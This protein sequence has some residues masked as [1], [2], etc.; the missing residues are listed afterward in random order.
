MQIASKGGKATDGLRISISA[1]SNVQFA[2]ANVNASSIW[3]KDWQCVTSSL[4]LL[5]HLLLRSCR[6]DAR[7]ADSEQTPNRDRRRKPANVIT[8]LYATQT[9][10]FRSGL[11]PG[12]NVG[13]GCSCHPTGFT[14][15]ARLA[16]LYILSGREGPV[17]RLSGRININE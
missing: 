14:I 1:D 17:A 16:F 5:G 13:A 8:R 6:S 9:H 10:A 7:G 2:G 12:T 15:I 11:E 4:A 3:M